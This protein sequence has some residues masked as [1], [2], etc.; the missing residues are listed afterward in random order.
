[1][2]CDRLSLRGWNPH[3]LCTQPV[4]SLR[5]KQANVQMRSTVTRCRRLRVLHL[6]HSVRAPDAPVLSAIPSRISVLKA[7]PLARFPNHMSE[8]GPVRGG[9]GERHTLAT[10]PGKYAHL[11]MW[12]Y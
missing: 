3:E 9:G 8:N 4:W 11:P 5:P 12:S 10:D 6:S 2:S 1:M 7:P